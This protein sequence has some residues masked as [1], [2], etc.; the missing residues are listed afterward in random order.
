MHGLSTEPFPMS[1]YV[2]SSKNLKDL[3]CLD[4][5]PRPGLAE[6]LLQPHVIVPV[7]RC[8]GV[9]DV[10]GLRLAAPGVFAGTAAVRYDVAAEAIACETWETI[11]KM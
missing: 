7:H 11:L 6:P 10:P 9:S 4:P 5:A 3:K 1:A 8:T 2:R